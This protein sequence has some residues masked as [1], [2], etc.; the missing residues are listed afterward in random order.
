MEEDLYCPECGE[1]DNI[2]YERTTASQ[3]TDKGTFHYVCDYC[4]E[5]FTRTED[6]NG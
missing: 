5:E 2:M 1:E 6:M 4:G 3:F